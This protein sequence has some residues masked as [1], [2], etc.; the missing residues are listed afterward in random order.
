M[1]AEQVADV[2]DA[3]QACSY[4]AELALQDQA[5]AERMARLS[6][7]NPNAMAAHIDT[8]AARQ[9]AAEVPEHKLAA[10]ELAKPEV[11]VKPNVDVAPERLAEVLVAEPRVVA[12]V[13]DSRPEAVRE[14]LYMAAEQRQVHIV[15]E[16]ELA[17]AL[18]IPR[19]ESAKKPLLSRSEVVPVTTRSPAALRTK[20]LEK[21]ADPEVIAKDLAAAEVHP[22]H[23]RVEHLE[24]L[25]AL[26]GVPDA[27]QRELSAESPL[28][29]S[30][31]ETV[32]V[33]QV[34]ELPMEEYSMLSEGY[35]ELTEVLVD[36]DPADLENTS[37]YAVA[38]DVVALYEQLL[39]LDMV[40]SPEAE[41]SDTT[42]VEGPIAAPAHQD[43]ETF[44]LD[45]ATRKL[46]IETVPVADLETILT[47]VDD[48]PL[49][50]TI[51]ALAEYLQDTPAESRP[52]ELVADIEAITAVLAVA[53]REQAPDGEA[54]PLQLTPEITEKL[55]RLLEDLGYQH[56]A[57]ALLQ[58]VTDY[59][60]DFLLQA[61]EYLCQLTHEENRQEFASRQFGASVTGDDSFRRRLGAGL[62][63]MITKFA[64]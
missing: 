25:T 23:V 53:T 62:L 31:T 59:D 36:S 12:E 50:V 10:A 55:L 44:V 64:A 56:P 47:E 37:E 52:A 33:P 29:D 30:L 21:S 7:A 40:N 60:L 41:N 5:A 20:S 15:A 28:I 58:T 42:E 63:G 17:E 39:A 9:Q 43:F 61:F 4:L 2:R 35:T 49:E 6:M 57:E 38:P 16:R 51:L 26:G 1:S 3:L 32:A 54:E 46:E 8:Q 24:V 14:V 45:Q 48:R 13:V 22:T 34:A 18:V 19:P 27:G 11:A